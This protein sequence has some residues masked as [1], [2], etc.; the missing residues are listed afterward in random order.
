VLAA[1]RPKMLELA[2]DRSHGA[3]SYLVTPRHTARARERLGPRPLLVPEQ[4]VVLEADPDRAREVAR[5][6]LAGYLQL[7]NYVNSWREEGFEEADFADGGSDRL[8]DALVAW[9]DVDAVAARVG[10]HLDAGADHVAVQPV[11]TDVGRALDELR[12][13]APALLR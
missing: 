13:L 4:G 3:H 10:E 9:G 5:K 1:L 2:R 8:V 12:A 7:P 11:T 6:H